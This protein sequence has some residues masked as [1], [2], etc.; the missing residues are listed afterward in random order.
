[1]AVAGDESPA[2]GHFG[3]ISRYASRFCPSFA[4]P[5]SAPPPR[6]RM[7]PATVRRAWLPLPVLGS[8]LIG[9]TAMDVDVLDGE[10]AVVLVVSLL[11]D[12]VGAAVV[13]VVDDVVDEEVDDDVVG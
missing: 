13:D 9:D 8:S 3:S 11:L 1:V 6:S 2:T 7:M 5:S 12:V 10:T 4:L